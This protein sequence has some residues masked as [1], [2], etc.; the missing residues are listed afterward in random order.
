MNLFNIT[1]VKYWFLYKSFNTKVFL[2]KRREPGHWD[3]DGKVY[4]FHF[5][6]VRYCTGT[7]SFPCF[8]VLTGTKKQ[9]PS[10]WKKGGFQRVF[11]KS[12]YRVWQR[13]LQGHCPHLCASRLF[14]L[15]LEDIILC[16]RRRAIFF[17]ATS[18]AH[19][20][21]NQPLGATAGVDLVPLREEEQGLEIRE[22]DDYNHSS[23]TVGYYVKTLT[24]FFH[25][26]YV[27]GRWSYPPAA[28][29]I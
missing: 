21:S 11:V 2:K 27:L 10:T 19:D 28:L 14:A 26:C 24:M 18:L 13:D 8:D 4:E 25:F 1:Y 7:P 9:Y 3:L 16:V 5:L 22:A 12:I 6:S 20:W 23:Y 15:V 17:Q 29:Y